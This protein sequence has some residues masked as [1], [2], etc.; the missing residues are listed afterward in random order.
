MHR[1]QRDEVVEQLRLDR[2]DEFD[3]LRRKAARWTRDHSD[4]LQQGDPEVPPLL[5][6]R[7]A[8]N[9][10]PLLAIADLAEGP[11]PERAREAALVLNGVPQEADQTPAIQLLEDIRFVFDERGV[12]RLGSE[13]I[14]RALI[15]MEDRPWAEWNRGRPISKPQIANRLKPFDIRSRTIRIGDRTLRGY[16]RE[17]FEDAWARYLPAEVQHPQPSLK[18]ND[19]GPER[20]RNTVGDCCAPDELLS[21]DAPRDVADVA[22]RPRAIESL[23]VLDEFLELEAEDEAGARLLGEIREGHASASSDGDYNHI[24][25]EAIEEEGE[26]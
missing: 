26:L 3:A 10:R 2:L 21:P 15:E 1:A 14:A 5:G 24:E 9:W 4:E 20:E 23:R 12:D 8:D 16:Q 13:E 25:R 7:P 6:N 17:W 19:L 18:D 22:A 11:W